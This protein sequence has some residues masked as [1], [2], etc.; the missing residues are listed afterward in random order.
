MISSAIFRKF[1]QM[2]PQSRLG[3]AFLT[4]ALIMVTFFFL[5]PVIMTALFSFTNMSTATGISG[6]DYVIT[7][8][9]LTR[10]QDQ[11]FL[12][13]KLL[14]V[15][16][17]KKY[18]IDADKRAALNNLSLPPNFIDHLFEKYDGQSFAKSQKLLRL[19]KK[20]P[21]RP[22]NIRLL[23]KTI[24][25]FETSLIN[26]RYSTETDFRQALASLPINLSDAQTAYLVSESYTG[27]QWRFDNFT[28]LMEKPNTLHIA[29]NSVVYVTATLIFNVAFGLF[30]ALTTFYLPKGQA[31][32]YRAIWLLPRISPP[33]L[34]VLLWK[35]F[36]W[37]DGFLSTFL[38]WFGIPS[39][40]YMVGSELSAWLVVILING[41][42]G[43][44]LGMILF[45][46]A[47]QAI[48]AS[49]I[50]A[51]QVDG[52]SRWQQIFHILLPQLRWPILFVSCYTTLSLLTSF[53]YILLSTEGGPGSTTTVW[54]LEAYFT[55]LS[56]Y[57]GNLQYGL[58]AAMA[59][60]LVI[61]GISLSF[62][63]MRV[64][65]FNELVSPP[66]IEQ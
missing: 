9:N 40:N 58:G 15:L 23:K 6:G 55:A 50:Y 54:S 7:P 34:Y 11:P 45:A 61:I 13:Q 28:Q 17:E 52:A 51:S 24:S 35:W 46:S 38:G 10:F 56:N 36:T 44:S 48:P 2:S 22:R 47:L 63:Y 12:D 5:L 43:A 31:A 4:P 19:L 20:V 16:A 33:V 66:K 30:L 8:A 26:R 59:L 42:V 53:E 57:S 62:L 41:F 3:L 1:H 29:I 14:A 39:F 18:V 25:L 37:D 49:Q 65:R 64:F 21:E 60:L 32:F 27:W